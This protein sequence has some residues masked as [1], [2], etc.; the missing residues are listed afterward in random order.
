MRYIPRHVKDMDKET[1]TYFRH[2]AD[3]LSQSKICTEY[4]TKILDLVLSIF[5]QICTE[6]K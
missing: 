5:I 1:L 6:K 4:A 3:I 2:I